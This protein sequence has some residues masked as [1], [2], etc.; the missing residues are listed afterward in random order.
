[1]IAGATP[2]IGKLV[3]QTKYGRLFEQPDTS[4]FAKDAGRLAGT[5]KRNVQYWT[6][7]DLVVP[8]VEGN[9][10][11]GKTG[12]GRARKYSLLNC[13]ELAIISRLAEDGLGQAVIKMAMLAIGG[14]RHHVFGVDDAYLLIYRDKDAFKV[15]VYWNLT[16]WDKVL[17]QEE[18]QNYDKIFIVNLA[19]IRNE[20]LARVG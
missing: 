14:W 2:D 10:G 18:P 19:K 20:V 7:Q 17:G 6:D 3:V 5:T 11:K 8:D 12:Q 15:Q 1:L 9:P 16:S 4:F 13:V